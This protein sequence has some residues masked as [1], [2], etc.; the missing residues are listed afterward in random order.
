MGN[1]IVIENK[2]RLINTMT[3]MEA[4]I[5]IIVHSSH[6]NSHTHDNLCVVPTLAYAHV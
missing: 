6:M 2:G 3:G 4:E 5:I 1:Y